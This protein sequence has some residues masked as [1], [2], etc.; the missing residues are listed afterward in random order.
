MHGTPVDFC[1][2]FLI[3]VYGE[4]ASLRR[5]IVILDETCDGY[6]REY[7]LLVHRDS[8]PSC[9]AVCRALAVDNER[10]QV[11]RQTRYPGQGY[12][13]REGFSA[14]TGT[15]FLMMNADLETDPRDA[16]C[17][18]ETILR[19]GYDMV[20]ASRFVAGGHVDATS[21][22]RLHLLMTRSFQILC[23]SAFRT[24]IRDL[25]FAYKIGTRELFQ[26]FEWR[27]TG[28]EIALETTLRPLAGGCR[29]GEV[30]TSWQ[31]REEGVSHHRF[32]RNLRYLCAA[33]RIWA[34]RRA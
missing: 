11:H 23:A 31:G 1:V 12:A 10:V 24:R 9:W 6:A 13:Y 30:P 33:A 21:Y 28:H 5:T 7:W 22:G 20:I 25:T 8:G 18:I 17:L 27:S 14:A 26:S 32:R 2:S 15:H 3:P 29:V 34:E 16:R 19:G 4:E